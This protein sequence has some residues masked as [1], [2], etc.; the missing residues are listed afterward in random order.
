MFNG[1][2]VYWLSLWIAKVISGLEMVKYISLPINLLCTKRSSM[3]SSSSRL[4]LKFGSIGSI[5][6]LLPK[7]PVSSSKDKV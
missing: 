1:F 2:F 3:G 6:G 4:S 7:K 5:L